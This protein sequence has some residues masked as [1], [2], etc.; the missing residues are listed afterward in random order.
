MKFEIATEKDLN[1]I[2][3][4]LEKNNLPISDI[5]KNSAIDFIIARNN[6][7]IIGCIA[8]EKYGTDGFLRSLAVDLDFRNKGYGNQLYNRLLSYAVQNEIKIMHLLTTTAE[9]YFLKKGFK[10]F[11]RNE[12]PEIIQK[13]VEF[14]ELCPSSSVYM[15][16]ENVSEHAAY[17]DGNLQLNHVDDQ[18]KSKYWTVKGEKM[19]FTHFVVPPDSVFEKHSHHSEQITYILDGELF[20]EIHDQVFHLKKGDSIVVPS[21]AEHKVWTQIGAVAVDSWTPLNEKY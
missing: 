11:N 15:I 16:L 4:L 2:K 7:R 5:S 14:S 9:K 13:T 21:N 20:F 6:K 1:A 10:K 17:Y 19:M 3:I 18:T 8:I 12:A